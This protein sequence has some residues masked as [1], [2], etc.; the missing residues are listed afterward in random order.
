MKKSLATAGTARGLHLET[1]D[2]RLPARLA[3][4]TG[5]SHSYMDNDE[6]IARV[7]QA[8][9]EDFRRFWKLECQYDPTNLFR[10]NQSIPPC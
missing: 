10:R 8:F 6:R 1:R 7:R 5:W 2:L 4:L 9:G 3:I